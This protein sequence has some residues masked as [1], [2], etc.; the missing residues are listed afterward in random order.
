MFLF[1]NVA[2]NYM[3]V[4]HVYVNLEDKYMTVAQKKMMM[5]QL[6]SYHSFMGP[7]FIVITVT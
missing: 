4:N 5:S 6:D 3:Y 7:S 1:N 2:V